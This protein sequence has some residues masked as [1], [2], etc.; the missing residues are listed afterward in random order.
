MEGVIVLYYTKQ[1]CISSIVK[2][3]V[4]ILELVLAFLSGLCFCF[5]DLRWNLRLI[6]GPLFQL[7]F[8]TDL[9]STICV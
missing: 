5:W 9:S 8:T 4:Q 7:T 6:I 3:I 2:S 1:S